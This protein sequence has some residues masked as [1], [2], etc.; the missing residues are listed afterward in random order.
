[1][2]YQISNQHVQCLQVGSRHR[3][4]H[5]RPRARTDSPQGRRRQQRQ[6]INIQ[7]KTVECKRINCTKLV[8]VV[9]QHDGPLQLV[10]VNE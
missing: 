4:P 5:R 7:V 3:R 8:R 10:P 1:M 6:R 2:F 9:D